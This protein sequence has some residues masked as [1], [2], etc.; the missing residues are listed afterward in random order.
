M[1]CIVKEL[2]YWGQIL[3]LP[4]YGLSFLIPRKKTIWLFGSTFGNRFAD[5]PKYF[6]LYVNQNHKD[7]RAIWISKKQK[8]VK[9][10]VEQGY[11][12]YYSKSLKG[13]W[14]SL[15][16]KI[17]LFDNYSKDI[18][19]WLSGGAIKYN[20]WHGIPLKKI[21]MDNIFDK[22]RHPKNKWG[23][24]K[25]ALRRL[26]DEKPSHY[27]VSPSKFLEA[28]YSSAFRTNNV[29]V[30]S[31]PRNEYLLTSLIENVYLAKEANVL[32]FIERKKVGKKVVLYMPTFRDS[33]A[34]FFDVVNIEKLNEFIEQE[35][36][37]LI[38]KLHP[39]SKL[40]KVFSD[41]QHGNIIVLPSD[42]DPY[43]F[44]K[45]SD[46]LVTDYSSIY[47]DYLLLDRPIIFFDYDKEE[48]LAHSRELYFDYEEFT[49]GI[50][51]KTMQ[52]LEDALLSVNSV[53]EWSEKRKV[54]RNKVMKE[55]T[56]HELLL[57]FEEIKGLVDN[58]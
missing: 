6:Y 34:M 46:M 38:I 15:R 44:L 21:Q 29:E 25:W 20:F 57:L 47:F 55:R 24:I 56:D 26:S 35:E 12:A 31:Y 37:L 39:K 40:K 52:E 28:I 54:I 16:G 50:K 27:I 8:I 9:N 36:F 19:F 7:I 1:K 13:I 18:C 17:Y 43:P 4:I 58:K 30:Y 3:M 49:P 41:M 32:E 33:E 53:D 22:V 48:Y 51:A 23:K 2:K 45:V 11:E 10:L 14:F 5:N 42:Y